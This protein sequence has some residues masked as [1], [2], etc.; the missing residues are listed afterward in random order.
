MSDTGPV[1]RTSYSRR[2]T[3]ATAALFMLHLVWVLFEVFGRLDGEYAGVHAEELAN[4]WMSRML[5]AGYWEHWTELRYRSFCGGCAVLGTLGVVPIS[6][7]G[8]TIV[9]WKLVPMLFHSGVVGLSIW[10]ARRWWGAAAGLLV[11]ALW[12]GAPS[13]FL[14]LALIGWGNHAEVMVLVLGTLVVLGRGRSTP[15]ATLSGAIAGFAVWFSRTGALVLPAALWVLIRQHGQREERRA[16]RAFVVAA[17]VMQLLHLNGASA[18]FRHKEPL[19]PEMIGG[20][21]VLGAPLELAGWLLGPV[22]R[23]RL[24]PPLAADALP[25][26]YWALLLVGVVVVLGVSLRAGKNRELGV[27]LPVLLLLG[28]VAGMVIGHV[29]W[30]DITTAGSSGAFNLRYLSP[31]FAIC[32]LFVGAASA[33]QSRWLRRGIW[34]V[35]L[36]GIGLRL[37]TWDVPR[38]DLVDRPLPTALGRAPAF[39][40]LSLDELGAALA[41]RREDPVT[42]REGYVRTAGERFFQ[43]HLDALEESAANGRIIRDEARALRGAV[44]TRDPSDALDKLTVW[45]DEPL[46]DAG[47]VGFESSLDW[48]ERRAL[49]HQLLPRALPPSWDMDGWNPTGGWLAR[50]RS[51]LGPESLRTLDFVLGEL[52]AAA[53]GQG[54]EQSVIGAVTGEVRA[55]VCFAAGTASG[56][57]AALTRDSA[58]GA[59]VGEAPAACEAEWWAAGVTLGSWRVEGCK[60]GSVE[61]E[62]GRLCRD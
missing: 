19:R 10:L 58:D 25:A 4:P 6:T 50:V 8:P 39:E 21:E 52:M 36:L 56:E 34:L 3:V 2:L 40:Q 42:L 49:W 15:R 47:F 20:P 26:V 24:W 22:V 35:P 61:F 5:L 12:L 55:G 32:V 59:S 1:L 37:M 31:F 43:R 53:A 23:G 33:S 7:L 28:W 45:K 17:S 14:E 29:H 57:S 46:L 9:A 48:W 16:L 38:F 44:E 30:K 41:G 54:R 51:E 13:I 62:G 11:A 27:A 18:R 60:R